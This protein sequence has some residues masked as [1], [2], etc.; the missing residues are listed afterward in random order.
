M[1]RILVANDPRPPGIDYGAITERQAEYWFRE[2]LKPRAMP[3]TASALYDAARSVM[4]DWRY[5][6]EI[7][8]V[9]KTI[10]FRRFE[11]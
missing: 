1:N 2:C 8:R 3:F 6:R 10:K 5:K 9:E 11:Q 4:G 7:N